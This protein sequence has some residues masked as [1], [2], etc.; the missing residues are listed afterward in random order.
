MFLD[1]QES[2]LHIPYLRKTVFMTCIF[3]EKSMKP[4]TE[5]HRNPDLQDVCY[6]FYIHFSC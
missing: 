2:T 3:L 5:T 1:A 4:K 6:Y